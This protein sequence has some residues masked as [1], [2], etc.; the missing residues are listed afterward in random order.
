MS[1]KTKVPMHFSVQVDEQFNQ[2]ANK[3]WHAQFMW[4]PMGYFRGDAH[5]PAAA[6]ALAWQ[7]FR[8]EVDPGKRWWALALTTGIP[9]Y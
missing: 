6:L 4:Y 8:R 9:R 3:R 7:N 2:P 5:S 1:D